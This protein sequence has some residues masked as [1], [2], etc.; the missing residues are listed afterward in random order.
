MTMRRDVNK[1]SNEINIMTEG[2]AKLQT[3]EYC[4][5]PTWLTIRVL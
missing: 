4:K 3:R 1:V 2:V 5:H